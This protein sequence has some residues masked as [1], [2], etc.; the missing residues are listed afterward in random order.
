MADDESATLKLSEASRRCGIE[1]AILR[2]L[3]E[4]RVLTAGVVRGKGGHA[5]IHEDAVPTW[6]EAVALI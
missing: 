5:Y 1:A 2:R 3:I 4:D 6:H